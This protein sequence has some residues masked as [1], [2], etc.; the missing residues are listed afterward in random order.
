MGIFD[1]ATSITIGGK[2]VASMKIG[3]AT[4]YE[5]QVTPSTRTV[6]IDNMD[7]YGTDY[8]QSCT[9]TLNGVTQQ[10]SGNHATVT[11]EDVPDGEYTVTYSGH[12]S[13]DNPI[14]VDETHTSFTMKW[15]YVG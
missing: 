8:L 1:N 2:E 12:T 7:S 6:T 15:R 9:L 5:K 11:F 10:S 14:T 13:T 3:E 4:I